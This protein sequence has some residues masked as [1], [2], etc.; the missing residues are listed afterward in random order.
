MASAVAS[1]NLDSELIQL[2]DDFAVPNSRLE[3]IKLEFKSEFDGLKPTWLD[4]LKHAVAMANSGGGMLVF[5]VDKNG[6]R[7][8]IRSSLLQTL[9]PANVS[10]KLRSFTGGRV[11]TSYRELV[12]AGKLFGFLQV[13]A[14]EKLV[15]FE[16]DGNFQG[17]DG[18][19][20][21][22]FIK[23]VIYTRIPGSTREA[24][25][26]DLDLLI[27]RFVQSRVSRIVA[28]IEHVAHAP[29][30]SDLVVSRSDDTSRGFVVGKS[31]PVR[32]VP[33]SERTPTETVPLRVRLAENDPDAVPIA[34][35]ADSAVPFSSVDLELQTQL[36]LWR[37]SD[38]NH[39]VS[40][41]ALCKFY[42]HRNELTIS[43]EAAEVCFI[44]AAYARGYP[45]F[46]AN[47][48]DRDRLRK[49]VDRE[50]LH[51][52]SPMTETLP[53][54][55]CA[56]LWKD[57]QLLSQP[58]AKTVRQL[59]ARNIVSTL[60]KFG[61]QPEFVRRA[62]RGGTSFELDGQ[63]YSIYA[64]AADRTSA[65]PVFERLVQMEYAGT[66]DDKLRTFAHRLDLIL[67]A[68]TN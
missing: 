43:P 49:V 20:G 24:E 66:I 26:V 12:D 32:I 21:R 35:V 15:V 6:N 3:P 13:V 55:V 64:L 39:R 33:E 11:A 8:G 4:L 36:R 45:M 25:Q 46:W 1:K 61:S 30:E 60:L 19:P 40:R 17:L 5:G 50:I 10:N 54:V 62:R 63:K 48:M 38:A 7:V 65:I 9:D 29:L 47:R 68:D 57:R 41:S 2:L 51:G 44:S 31:M 42:V 16:S 18:K 14:G 22:A 56:F 28:R 37:H 67:H 59:K 52:K 34:E 53:F 27:D 58:P 23:G